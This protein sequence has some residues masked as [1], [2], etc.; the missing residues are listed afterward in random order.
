MEYPE[1]KIS[2][3]ADIGKFV[4]AHE[5]E[6][7]PTYK[8]YIDVSAELPMQELM[9]QTIKIMGPPKAIEDYHRWLKNN[10]FSASEPNPT[11]KF[12]SKYFG[13]DYLW[14]TKYSQGIVVKNINKE[15]DDYYI[16]MECSRLNTGYKYSKILLTPLGCL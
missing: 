14:R 1:G 3:S 16:V 9:I 13:K 7:N 10:H 6:L 15:D 4:E 5:Y 2:L 11:N 8:Y 12:V